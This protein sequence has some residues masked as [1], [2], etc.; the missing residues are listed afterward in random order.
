M[1]QE[2]GNMQNQRNKQGWVQIPV[3]CRQRAAPFYRRKRVEDKEFQAVGILYADPLK[4]A[5]F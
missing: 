1:M 2:Q 5:D 3:S 4:Y